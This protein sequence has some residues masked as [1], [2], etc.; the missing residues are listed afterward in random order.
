MNTALDDAM[1]TAPATLVSL[2]GT[3]SSF[4]YA[5][6]LPEPEPT[7]KHDNA[8]LVFIVGFAIINLASTHNTAELYLAKCI[9]CVPPL[10]RM[11]V[12]RTLMSL[13][14]LA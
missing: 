7:P 3:L 5:A 1:P 10:T 13:L 4:A 11:L 14:H 6:G 8:V 2:A 12:M 9:M